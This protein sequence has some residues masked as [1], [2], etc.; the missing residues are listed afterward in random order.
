MRVQSTESS[1]TKSDR[2]WEEDVIVKCQ[3]VTQH[4]PRRT[5]EK[6][7]NLRIVGPPVKNCPQDVPNTK[8]ECHQL[9]QDLR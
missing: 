9:D 8:Q 7:E 6:H 1:I 5:E 3:V 2:K 4:L